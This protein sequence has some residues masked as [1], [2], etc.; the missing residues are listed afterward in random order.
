MPVAV[1]MHP[2][3]VKPVVADV[4]AAGGKVAD[5]YLCVPVCGVGRTLW[6]W[7]GFAARCAPG[8]P[9]RR[10]RRPHALLHG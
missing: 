8:T 4:A 3:H 10:R 1:Q 5:S 6:V 7:Q 9:C 2:S